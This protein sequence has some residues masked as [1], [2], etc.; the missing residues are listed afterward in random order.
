VPIRSKQQ[1]VDLRAGQERDQ[2]AHVALAGNGQHALDLRG[3][4][5]RLERRKAK[6]GMDRGESQV[7]TSN[8]DAAPL[9][10]VIEERHDQGRIDLLEVQ[11]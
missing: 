7:A 8:A 2:G 11:A 9:L 5:R 1:G 4:R 10:Q 6:E 3:V